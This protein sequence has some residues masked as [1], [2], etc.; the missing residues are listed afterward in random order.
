MEQI[1]PG[2]GLFAEA[3][4]ALPEISRVSSFGKNQKK[5]ARLTH[6]RE[7]RERK[8]NFDVRKA[9]VEAEYSHIKRPV[10]PKTKRHLEPAHKFEVTV[11]PDSISQRK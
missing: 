8:Q 11:E 1:R 3:C 2:T 9:V 10:D 5:A 4:R 7:K 6:I